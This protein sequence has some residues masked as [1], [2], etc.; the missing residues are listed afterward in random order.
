VTCPECGAKV[1]GEREKCFYCGTEVARQAEARMPPGAPSTGTPQALVATPRRHA[2]AVWALV[3]GII[4]WFAFSV[5]FYGLIIASVS[6]LLAVILGA[7]SIRKVGHSGS[8]LKGKA[9][10]IWGLVLGTVVIVCV[11]VV[12]V[13]YFTDRSYPQ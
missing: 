3:T 6:A 2:G 11:I 12:L 7:T 10:A 13:R 1:E 4:G 9:M 8:R 5:P